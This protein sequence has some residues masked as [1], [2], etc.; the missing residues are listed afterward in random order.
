MRGI[1]VNHVAYVMEHG[2]HDHGLGGPI[3]FSPMAALQRVLELVDRFSILEL[4]FGGKQ[5]RNGRQELC[6][7]LMRRHHQIE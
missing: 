5:S 3:L 6:C 7:L 2:S 1:T 4:P